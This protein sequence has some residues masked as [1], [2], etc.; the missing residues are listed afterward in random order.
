MAKKE[1]IQVLVWV[2]RYEK[3]KYTDYDGEVYFYTD[4]NELMKNLLL[5]GKKHFCFSDKSQREFLEAYKNGNIKHCVVEKNI[6]SNTEKLTY[7]NLADG[8]Y[9]VGRRV[10][11]EDINNGNAYLRIMTSSVRNSWYSGIY[12]KLSNVRDLDESEKEIIDRSLEQSLGTGQL[13]RVF[14]LFALLCYAKNVVWRNYRDAKTLDGLSRNWFDDKRERSFLGFSTM[15]LFHKDDVETRER[16]AERT[17]RFA[18]QLTKELTGYEL[19]LKDYPDDDFVEG[20]MSARYLQNE[21]VIINK[22]GEPTMTMKELLMK[23]KSKETGVDFIAAQLCLGKFI[24]GVGA[25]A[26]GIHWLDD[27]TDMTGVKRIEVSP[28]HLGV[29]ITVKDF[30]DIDNCYAWN[31]HGE[32]KNFVLYIWDEMI[33]THD[34]FDNDET[35]IKVITN[36]Q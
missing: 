8:D 6:N 30:N 22:V 33:M 27:L 3:K 1:K 29:D 14:N 20:L 9:F 25:N 23:A 19:K 18:Y 35:F 28:Y 4:L 24:N 21:S 16:V 13:D 11:V 26:N 5:G 7:E 10:T 17:A 32:D 15:D 36:N 31:C 12:C 2:G 34:M